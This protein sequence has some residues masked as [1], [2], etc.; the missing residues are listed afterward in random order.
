[1]AVDLGSVGSTLGLG[2]I[3]GN[4]S[5]VA[6][7]IAIVFIV[8]IVA[9]GIVFFLVRYMR[10]NK[11]L[12]L[13]QS[14]NGQTQETGRV[15]AAEVPLGREGT[16]VFRILKG[17]KILPRP[18]IQIKRNVYSYF[19]TDDGEWLNVGLGDLNK[20]LKEIGLY[21]LS[22]DMRY[23]RDSIAPQLKERFDKQSFLQKYG[24]AIS[25][26]IFFIIAGVGFWL[27]FSQMAKTAAVVNSVVPQLKDVAD[28]LKA[29]ATSIA[30]AHASSGVVPV[31]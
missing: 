22:T 27:M 21:S 3:G 28:S 2:N 25:M 11:L 23:A 10:Y 13:Y 12:I 15:K 1:M 29:A 4:F 31:G 20:P 17:R 6:T 14:V 19:I 16:R 30:Q 24:P 26:M 7:T 18:L 8:A 9:G 5:R